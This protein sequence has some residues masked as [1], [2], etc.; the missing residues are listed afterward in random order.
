MKKASGIISGLMYLILGILFVILKTEV[1]GIAMT[2]MGIALIVLGIIDFVKARV[3][4]GLLK[5][6]A[7]VV[8]FVFE[9][10]LIEFAGIVM[11]VILLVW[12]IIALIRKIR[13]KRKPKKF[14]ANLVGYLVPVVCILGGIFL[15]TGGIGS[16]LT[17]AF[18]IAGVL[19]IINGALAII[20]AL[21]S[22][23]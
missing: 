16:A 15:L 18:I 22:K 3:F 12:G 6:L 2:V 8:I 20:E 5:I 7:A 17:W 13:S 4:L 10:K 19:L 1:I 14:L 11:G 21:T 23:K 9:W